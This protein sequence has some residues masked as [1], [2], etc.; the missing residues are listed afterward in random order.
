[1]QLFT[2]VGE[3]RSLALTTLRLFVEAVADDDRA[4]LAEAIL[5]TAVPGSPDNSQ[6]TVAGTIGVALDL[7]ETILPSA[8]P[9][10]PQ[11]PTRSSFSGI[12]LTR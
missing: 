9:R 6:A 2:P 1:M 7:L 11:A 5:A 8:K 4:E 10:G 3:A 12:T